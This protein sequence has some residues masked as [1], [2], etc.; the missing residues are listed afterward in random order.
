MMRRSYYE[1]IKNQ[2]KVK[3]VAQAQENNAHRAKMTLLAAA[4]AGI[5]YFFGYN[6]WHAL[7]GG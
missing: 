2:P 6:V 4:S 3:V 1:L 7:L 5:F